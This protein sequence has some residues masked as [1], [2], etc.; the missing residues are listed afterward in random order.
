LKRAKQKYDGQANH[1]NEVNTTHEK[2]YLSLQ[3]QP[4]KEPTL[5]H[6]CTTENIIT[7]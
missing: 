7:D 1:N 2:Q 5:Q 3:N 6:Y 4:V